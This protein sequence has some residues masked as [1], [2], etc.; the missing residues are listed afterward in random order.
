MA[1]NSMPLW[2]A[3]WTT[4]YRGGGKGP[5]SGGARNWKYVKPA[6][7]TPNITV[8]IMMSE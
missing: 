3:W 8:A 4:L 2:V 1:R 5:Q 7:M 6:A